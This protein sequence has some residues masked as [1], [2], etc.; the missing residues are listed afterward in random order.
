MCRKSK[1]VGSSYEE[2]RGG[3]DDSQSADCDTEI[4][5]GAPAG[6][7]RDRSDDQGDLNEN[8]S[9]V[10][11]VGL[12]TVQRDFVLKLAGL[13][14]ELVLFVLVLDGLLTKAL[15]EFGGLARILRL[16]DRYEL[17]EGCILV[18]TNIFRLILRP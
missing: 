1:D 18:G 15:I 9:E 14:L 3:S 4:P 2:A 8:L 5:K 10:E 13:C 12:A 11:A 17:G 16:K 6:Q 7:Q